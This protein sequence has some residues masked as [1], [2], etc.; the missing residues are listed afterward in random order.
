MN[1]V[2]FITLIKIK[3]RTMKDLSCYSCKHWS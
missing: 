1:F 3:W 2:S